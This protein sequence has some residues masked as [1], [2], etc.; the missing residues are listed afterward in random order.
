MNS[1]HVQ[2]FQFLRKY[3][4]V[5]AGLFALLTGGLVL[6]G[7][8]FDLHTLK[9]ILPGANSMKP[10][11][12]VALVIA[13]LSLLLLS[14]G[15]AIESAS[16]KQTRKR[17]GQLCALFIALLALLTLGEY[18]FGWDFNIDQLLFRDDS[19]RTAVF[20]PGRMAPPTALNFVLLATSLLLLSTRL[21]QGQ[22]VGASLTLIA[23]FI[24]LLAILGYAYNVPSFQRIASFSSIALH[25]AVALF[26]LC[27]GIV[28]A[29]ENRSP[30][31]GILRDTT[32]G[33]LARRLLPA[34]LIVPFVVGWLRLQGERAGY[35]STEFGL[36]LFATT[37]IVILMSL[38]WLTA[39]SIDRTDAKRKQAENTLRESEARLRRLFEQASDG[40][41]IISPDNRYLAANTR[42]LEMLGYTEQELMQMGVAEV[43]VADE[44]ERL[45]IEPVLMMAGEPHLAEWEHLRKDGT[46][47][48]GEVS[49]RKLNDESYLA[50]VRDLTDRRR[51]EAALRESEARLNEAQRNALIG[52]WRYLPDGTLIWS[53][54]MYELFKLPRDV[55]PTHEAV[56]AV[57]HPEDQTVN[58]DLPFQHALKSAALNFKSEYRVIWPD[59][60]VRTFYSHGK[61][62]RQVPGQLI[63]AV[64]TVQ[65]VTERKRAEDE[66]GKNQQLLQ[67]IVDNSPA[68]IYVKDLEGRFLLVNRGL[69][70]LFNRS[71]EEIS[72]KNTHDLVAKEDADLHRANDLEVLRSGKPVVREESNQESDGVHTYYSVKFPLIGED[73]KPYALGGISTDI[74]EKKRAEE[75]VLREKHFS[76]TAIDALPG[77]FYLYDEKGHF[78]RWNKN[79]EQVSGYSAAEIALMHPLDFFAGEEKELL[80]RR[81]GE[82][83]FEGES[84]VEASFVGKDGTATPFFF[85]G[86]RIVLDQRPCLIGVGIDITER[87]QADQQILQS[88]EQLRALTAHLQDIREEERTRIAREVHDVL[89]Q[90]LTALKIDIRMFAKKLSD[91]ET[92]EGRLNLTKRINT[93]Q[94]LTDEVIKTVQQIS[95]EL[96]PGVLDSL[97]LVAAVEWQARDFEKRTDIACLCDL[98]AS[99]I[100]ISPEQATA[101]FRIFQEI[102]TNVARHAAATQVNIKLCCNND[103]VVLLVSDNGRGITQEQLTDAASLG[104]LGMQERARLLG[105]ALSVTAEP[106]V[107]TEVE[108]RLPIEAK[109]TD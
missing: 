46:T 14:D 54:Q 63:E 4:P 64:G 44:R 38:I 67:A 94:E 106:G 71:K 101:L 84:S 86:K 55:P 11:T 31:V 3:V 79:F 74:T 52:S 17:I 23:A 88:R 78:L 56:M 108:A 85:T 91:Y 28:I 57:V 104:L 49:A 27:V 62:H 80:Q 75:A 22:Q 95:S 13:G 40:I 109:N 45:D 96:R 107:G 50:I 48:V 34:A 87:K 9:T 89:G 20:S 29:L 26:V 2:S 99:A 30:G 19:P 15:S 43:L 105:G 83:F 76:D 103:E 10:N 72:A 102:L 59:G 5:S 42:G 70:E 53:D 66:L 65:D 68:H 60:Q 93:M 81:I 58:F 21:R 32:G 51:V 16:Q 12:A 36:A 1:Q 8:A 33:K 47:F 69:A 82:V 25:T 92:A 37:N 61:I 90:L 97:G 100:E 39:R 6:V 18:I 77:I 35:Y 41:F 98:P 73:L 7:W 24:S